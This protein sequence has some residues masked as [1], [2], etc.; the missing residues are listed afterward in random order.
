MKPSLIAEVE[1]L[2]GDPS[3]PV[4]QWLLFNGP[5]GNQFSW[6]QTRSDPPGYVGV[7]HLELIVTEQAGVSGNFLKRAQDAVTQSLSSTWPDILCRGIQV[8]A[9]IGSEEELSKLV[10]LNSRENASV[11]ANAKAASFYLKRRLRASK[12]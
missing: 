2:G 1:R 4:W 12:L 8:A 6:S 5:H 11:C 9:I 3:D 10:A 7:E